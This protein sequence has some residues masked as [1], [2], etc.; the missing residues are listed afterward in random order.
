MSVA[1]G[2]SKVGS[3][4]R[5][6]SG[7]RTRPILV[8]GTPRS[9]TTWVGSTIAACARLRYVHEPFN[10]HYHRPAI[11]SARFP[12]QFHYLCAENEAE[13][14]EP[15]MRTLQHRLNWTH[16]RQELHS[17]RDV[18][19]L[20]RTAV[21]L[22]MHRGLRSRCLIKDPIAV[23]STEWLATRCD[24]SV[25]FLVRHPAAFVS[26][27]KRKKSRA[28]LELLLQQPLLVRDWLSANVS[29]IEA[30]LQS[31]PSDLER[32]AHFWRV[33]H[34]LASRWRRL[35][36][37]WLFVRHE[38]LSRAPVD[39]FSRIHQALHLPFTAR[40]VSRIDEFSPSD[41]PSESP[42][43]SSV[44]KLNSQANIWNWT[45]RLTADEVAAV[46][47]IVQDVSSE[48]YSDA[49]WE[50]DQAAAVAA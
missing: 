1:M 29:E 44:Y 14:H 49:D 36:P 31:S 38:D 47:E 50:P 17:W 40:A 27:L 12:N 9:G 43:K 2:D 4:S 3:E 7:Q 22:A 21:S 24:M 42:V 39:G 33:V 5:R 10:P 23:L 35:H 30:V 19:Q 37:D 15:L 32:A 48:F 41:G 18:P 25:V 28:P 13:F 26:S 16:A 34:G 6:Q 11:C 45:H 8:T 46:R 20:C